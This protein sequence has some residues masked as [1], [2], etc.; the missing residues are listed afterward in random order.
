VS[1]IAVKNIWL[2][3][4]RDGFVQAIHTQIFAPAKPAYTTFLS[5]KKLASMLFDNRHDNTL[6]LYQSMTATQ[7]TKPR[8]KRI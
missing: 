5:M 2:A 3:K 1:L 4:M 8:D 7:Y 6:R